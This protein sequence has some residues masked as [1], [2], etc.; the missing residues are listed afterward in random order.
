VEEEV[1][2]VEEVEVT[3]FKLGIVK[4][5]FVSLNHVLAYRRY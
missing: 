1:M 5:S 2:E 3:N 4:Y